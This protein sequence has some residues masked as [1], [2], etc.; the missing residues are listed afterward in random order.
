MQ[1]PPLAERHLYDPA[2]PPITQFRGAWRPLSNFAPAVFTLDG[3]RFATS[4]HAF[5]ALKTLD[6]KERVLVASAPTPGEAKQRG[7][8]VTL[9]P[10]WD[11]TVR[12]EVMDRVLRAKFTAHPARVEFLL[13]TGRALLVEGVSWHDLIWGCCSCPQHNGAG[14]NHLGRALMRLRHEL[15]QAG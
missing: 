15:R 9:Q 7:R 5:N 10:G 2:V 8:R 6:P 13:S 14:E 1:M 4:E 3:L 11:E 12:F